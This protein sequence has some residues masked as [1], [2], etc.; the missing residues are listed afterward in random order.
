MAIGSKYPTFNL[1]YIKGIKNILGSD[2]NFAKWKAS[3]D[4]EKNFKLRGLLKYNVSLGG[5]LNRKEVFIQDYQ[6]FNGNRSSLAGEYLSSFQ[7]SSYYQNSTTALIY[8]I[9]HLEHHFN[10]LLTNKIPLFNRLNWNLVGGT[11]AFYVNS[12]S[13]HTEL[14]FGVENIL[15]IFRIDYVYGFE[16]GG[17]EKTSA[18]SIG[19][20]GLLGGS[21]N[22]VVKNGEKSNGF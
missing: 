15:K 4:G 19:F 2:V 12:K 9:I 1:S 20:G 7:L 14:F 5:F 6:H 21:L 18:I 8:G 10:G 13:N 17:R 3:V 22:S 16:N 11:N